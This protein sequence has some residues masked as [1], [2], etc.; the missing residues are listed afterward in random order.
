M[1]QYKYTHEIK[2]F[3]IQNNLKLLHG[4]SKQE[5]EIIIR[6]HFVIKYTIIKFTN[7]KRHYNREI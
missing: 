5:K 1:L 7:D 4:Q 6:N 2:S 3:K